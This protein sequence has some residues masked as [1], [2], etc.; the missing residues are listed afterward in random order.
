MHRPEE[1]LEIQSD[2]LFVSVMVHLPKEWNFGAS[3]ILPSP[4]IPPSLIVAK[5]LDSVGQL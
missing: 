5:L 3:T 2:W 1:S 4:A